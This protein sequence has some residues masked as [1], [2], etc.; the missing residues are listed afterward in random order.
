[1]SQDI[2]AW[3]KARGME[4][5]DRGRIPGAIVEEY[6]A[7]HPNG[8]RAPEFEDDDEPVLITS[9]AVPGYTDEPE[10]EPA[11]E[12]A[13]VVGRIEERKPQRPRRE[14]LN[15][16]RAKPKA[17][18]GKKAFPRTSTAD[19]LGMAY[20]GLGY[21]FSRSPD[22]VPVARSMDLIAPAAGEILDDA[23][24]GTIIDTFLQPLARSG[25]RGRKVGA[26]TLLP[27]TTAIVAKRPELYPGLKP[28]M[29]MAL[30]LSLEVSETPMKRIQKRA[31]AFQEKFGGIDL[32]AMLDGLF[33]DMDIPAQHSPEEDEAV[34]R[35]RGD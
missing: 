19:L 7:A 26:V 3:A 22:L 13:P 17:P 1:M 14:R 32:G 35:A 27:L 29:Q 30:I 12:P 20:S 10:P 11:E 6:E 33:A 5:S 18:D 25:D 15:R 23:V 31:E 8:A 16:L 24:K 34:R 21:V 28:V 2:R 4:V 9:Q